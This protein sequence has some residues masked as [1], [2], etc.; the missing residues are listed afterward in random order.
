MDSSQRLLTDKKIILKLNE[1]HFVLC[2]YRIAKNPVVNEE[3]TCLPM[4]PIAIATNGIV[5][6]NPWD[7]DDENAV[8]GD[9]AEVF[10]ECDGHPDGQGRFVYS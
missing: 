3:S 9:G 2:S 8:E 5:M 10:D 4:G 6:Y 7:T 1:F